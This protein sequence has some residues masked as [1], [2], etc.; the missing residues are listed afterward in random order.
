[1]IIAAG[2]LFLFLSSSL[3]D[4]DEV[5]RFVLFWPILFVLIGFGMILRNK[6]LYFLITVISVSAVSYLA[7]ADPYLWQKKEAASKEQAPPPNIIEAHDG[8]VSE[9]KL[10][11]DLNSAKITLKDFYDSNHNILLSGNYSEIRELETLRID[12]GGVVKLNIKDNSD[13]SKAPLSIPSTNKK[14]M[15]LEI[16]DQVPLDL[17][18]NSTIGNIDLDFSKINLKKLAV[19]TGTSALKIKFGN[20]SENLDA[21]IECSKSEISL[22]VPSDVGIKI[23]SDSELFGR[24]GSNFDLEQDGNIYQT[25]GF[26]EKKK[27]I[28]ITMTSGISEL[29]VK[30]Y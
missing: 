9:F 27:K 11:L 2:I 26:D 16:S 28:N 24:N 25:K 29:S 20:I 19:S 14:N 21:A 18:L 17:N 15:S 8:K 12:E 4:Y 7:I 3:I 22:L 1:M 10:M 13:A 23:I 30:T 6:L 5:S